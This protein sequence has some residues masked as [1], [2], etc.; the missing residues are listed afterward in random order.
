[1]TCGYEQTHCCEAPAPAAT[2]FELHVHEP[3]APEE[4]D[5]AGQA[6]HE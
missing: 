1:M 6:P 5:P 3:V 2:K 4:V